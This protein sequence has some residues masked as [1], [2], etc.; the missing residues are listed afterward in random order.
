[1]P[2][3]RNQVPGGGKGMRGGAVCH[4]RAISAGVQAVGLVDAVA[5]RALQFRGFGGV[6]AGVG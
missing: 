4:I 3:P 6:G 2:D 5:E 1:V